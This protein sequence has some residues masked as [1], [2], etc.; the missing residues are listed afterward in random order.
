[1]T[2]ILQDEI[3]DK[4]NIFIDDLPVKG[5]KSQYLDGHGNPETIAEN[6]G[7]RRFIWEHALD[8]HRIMHRVKHSGATFAPKKV[9]VCRPEVVIVGQ[10]CTP[11]GRE[12]DEAKIEKILKWP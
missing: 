11:E 7:I 9:Q 10:K 1:M 5:P 3:P 2:F 6:P 4:A 12:P 8:V